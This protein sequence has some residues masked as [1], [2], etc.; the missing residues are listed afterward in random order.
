MT[1]PPLLAIL[2]LDGVAVR[3]QHLEGCTKHVRIHVDQRPVICA[4]GGQRLPVLS[5]AA[6]DVIEVQRPLVCESA[7]DATMCSQLIE[8]LFAQSKVLASGVLGLVCR[9]PTPCAI[10]RP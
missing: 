3:A 1:P 5:A 4:P 6:I 8:Q 7:F 2:A 9:V 10:D